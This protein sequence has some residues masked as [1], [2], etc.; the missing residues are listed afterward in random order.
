VISPTFENSTPPGVDLYKTATL[1]IDEIYITYGIF[2]LKGKKIAYRRMTFLC[3]F[4][5]DV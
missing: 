3:D 1:W 5:V 4:K 2:P